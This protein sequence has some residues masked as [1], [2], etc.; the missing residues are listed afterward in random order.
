M[1]R[2]KRPNGQ[3][4]LF[5][6]VDG[7]LNTYA[8]MGLEEQLDER[9][10]ANLLRIIEEANPDVVLSSTWRFH[11]KYAM[12]V[13]RKVGYVGASTPRLDKGVRGHEIASYLSI[14]PGRKYVIVDDDSDMLPEQLPFFVQTAFATGLDDEATAKILS[15]Y[16]GF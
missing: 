4:F 12:R 2:R 15:L 10:V 5:L 13:W 16:K 3:P 7:V 14:H 9:C 11:Q 6:D 1:S 8:S